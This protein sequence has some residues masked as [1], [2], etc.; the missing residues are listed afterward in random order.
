MKDLISK[1]D[2]WKLLHEAGTFGF[3]KYGIHFDINRFISSSGF[4]FEIY[5]TSNHRQ[6]GQHWKMDQ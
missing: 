4:Y 3:W 1:T 6:K 2:W 5:I